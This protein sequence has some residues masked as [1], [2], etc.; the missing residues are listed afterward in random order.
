MK[1]GLSAANQGSPNVAY[2]AFDQADDAAEEAEDAAENGA[3]TSASAVSRA[4]GYTILAGAYSIQNN[5]AEAYQ[6]AILAGI[7]AQQA[8]PLE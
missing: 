2:D 5:Q 8:R 7:A 6:N 4:S 3:G 1:C